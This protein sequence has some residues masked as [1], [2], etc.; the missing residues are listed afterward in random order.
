MYYTNLVHLLHNGK[1][2]CTFENLCLDDGQ[3]SSFA[4][5]LEALLCWTQPDSELSRHIHDCDPEQV[6]AMESEHLLHLRRRAGAHPPALHW[7][8]AAAR[9]F[10]ILQQLENCRIQIRTQG[11]AASSHCLCRH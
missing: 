6:N 8:C 7:R 1:I 3:R 11:D 5:T 2:E 10:Q 4:L 9:T